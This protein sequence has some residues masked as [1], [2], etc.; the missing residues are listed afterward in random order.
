[1]A[2]AR[3]PAAKG[4]SATDRPAGL[5][6]PALT[7]LGLAAGDRVRFRR[8]DTERWK[9]ATVARREADGSLSVRDAR[10]G[11]RAIPIDA[12]EVRVV[13]PRGGITWESLTERA[14]RTEQMRLI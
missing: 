3:R 6:D 2:P 9:E 14:A 1:M 8:R 12:V 10:G 11:L 5:A 7:G 13:G 4:P